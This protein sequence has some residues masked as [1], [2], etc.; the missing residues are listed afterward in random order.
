MNLSQTS[1]D[2][3]EKIKIAEK[4]GRYN[5]HLDAVVSPEYIK[6][7]EN[8]RYIWSFKDKVKYFLLNKTIVHPYCFMVNHFWLKTKVYGKENLKG[9]KGGITTCNHVNKL[10]TIAL[11]KGFKHKTFRYTVAEFNNMNTRLGAYIRAFGSMP[12]SED[13]G[14]FKNFNKAVTKI[15]SDG[16]FINFFPEQSEW[17]CYEKPRPLLPGAFHYAA[18]N[19]C[20]II[21]CFISFTKTGKFDSNGIEKRKFN[22]HILK[23]IYPKPE[24]T[25][26]ENKE[27]LKDENMKAW[28]NKYE[29]FYQKPYDLN[30]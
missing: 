18:R 3:L 17:W 9:V 19:N 13:K 4:E 22:V 10:D 1:F 30:P 14:A 6:V 21:P 7:D 2:V 23:P 8:Y 15:V 12:I 28:I 29:E 16:G 24:L 11:K 26:K 25:L 5:D 20:P 27:Y